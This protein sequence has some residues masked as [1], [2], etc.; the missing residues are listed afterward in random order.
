MATEIQGKVGTGY[1]TDGSLADPRMTNDLA[2]VTQE[3]HGHFYETTYRGN[4]YEA[5]TA[6]TGVAP[7]TAIGTTAAFSLYNPAG[8]GKN[9]VI[10]DWSMGYVS[11]TIG[12]GTIYVCVNSNTV[13][14]ATT[15]TA[16]TVE[17]LLVGSPNNTVAKAFTTATLP[18]APIVLRP[19]WIL[20]A[21]AAATTDLPGSLR[22]IIDGKL[23]ITPGC[24]VSFEAVATAG[25]T[26]LVT[27]SMSW[28]EVNI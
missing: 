18:V 7:G 17:S 22:E 8:S 6:T 10:L 24:T 13:A 15:G 9:L 3:L 4:T 21:Q 23:I 1:A 25:T 12:G 28:E 11:G 2:L 27:F 16:I 26:P 14:A 20:A 19:V 5:V